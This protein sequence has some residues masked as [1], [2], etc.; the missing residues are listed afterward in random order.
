MTEN[1]ERLK[2]KA[3]AN[4]GIPFNLT[5]RELFATMAMQ[6]LMANCG[7]PIQANGNCGWSYCNSNPSEVAEVAVSVADALLLELSKQEDAK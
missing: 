7:G 5:K 4:G 2:R 3:Q 6:G 1:T